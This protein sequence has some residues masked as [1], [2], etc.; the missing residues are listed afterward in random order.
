MDTILGVP[1]LR[2]TGI[3]VSTSRLFFAPDGP[4]EEVYNFNEG[5]FTEQPARNL[6]DLGFTD[7]PMTSDDLH[8]FIIC[9]I[10]AGVP[11]SLVADVIDRVELKPHNP[12][13]DVDDDD[14]ALTD[15]T[16]A[17]ARSQLGDLLK[18]FDDI[19][20]DELPGPLPF[21]PV[22]HPIPLKDIEAK[23]RPRAIR[24]PGRYAA[25]WSVDLRKFVKMGFWSPA[26][27]D[28]ACAMFVV[29]KHNKSQAQ[30]VI[31]LKPRNNNT[32]KMKSPIPDMKEVRNCVASHCYHSKIDFKQA[33]KQLHLEPE[34]VP[35]SGFVTLNGTFVS[36]VMQQGDTNAPE[37]MHRVCYMM[38]AKAIGRFL[39]VFYD[40]VLIYSNT[41]CAHLRYLDIVLTT[42]RHYQFFLSC[43][44]A[45]F[46][47]ELLEVLGAQIDSQGIHVDGEKWD[48]IQSWPEPKCPKDVLRFMGTLQWM[49][50]HLS[51][52]NEIAAPCTR[53]T[54]KVSW[55]YSPAA[56]F[57]FSLLKSLVP[58]VLKP[59]D[60]AA[61]DAG[62]E[63]LYLFTD[64]SMFGCGGWVGQGR[65]RDDAR[66][67]WYFSYK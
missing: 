5:W 51:R 52:L 42:L 39:D 45:D 63:W 27:L 64:A 44:K 22:N 29:P 58:D 41:R 47:A 61:I 54:G 32:V 49:G 1:W 18:R 38:F 62:A 17:E 34:S 30:F 36:H 56:A 7:R 57:A 23:I 66:P 14:P 19:L 26:A 6:I 48:A 20:V 12:L 67:F 25:Q 11:G 59:L 50:D 55:D 16:D 24:I 21:R 4:S 33:Y 13:L 65:S 53:L 35:L 31:N 60:L 2:D 10:S 43:S 15:L 46:L 9:A 28:S 40:N 8:L 37:T 3:A